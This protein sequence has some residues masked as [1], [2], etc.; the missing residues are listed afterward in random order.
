MRPTVPRNLDRAS[1]GRG[2]RKAEAATGDGE[3]GLIEAERSLV[4]GGRRHVDEVSSGVA[5]ACVVPGSRDTGSIGWHAAHEEGGALVGTVAQEAQLHLAGAVVVA[6]VMDVAQAIDIL[7][8][9]TES[10][11]ELGGSPVT[12][13]ADEGPKDPEPTGAPTI[14]VGGSTCDGVVEKGQVT[15][16]RV[17]IA[18]LRSSDEVA[19][20]RAQVGEHRVGSPGHRGISVMAGSV[21]GIGKDIGGGAVHH[22]GLEARVDAVLEAIHAPTAALTEST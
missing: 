15:S 5:D 12:V 1:G 4:L 16:G 21:V 19:H 13:V 2:G 9:N 17:D 10:S 6:A 22:S 11:V 14:R 7:A 3:A 20:L 18:L 8:V